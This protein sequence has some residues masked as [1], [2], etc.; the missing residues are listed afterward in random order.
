MA[1]RIGVD[2]NVSTDEDM[3]GVHAQ[4]W[5]TI[6]TPPLP[7]DIEMGE[8]RSWPPEPVSC[9]FRD[10]RLWPPVTHPSAPNGHNWNTIAKYRERIKMG[11]P[12]EYHLQEE[13][14]WQRKEEREVKKE[15]DHYEANLKKGMPGDPN[16]Q[17]EWHRQRWE[18]SHAH[19]T[20]EER[21]KCRQNA[22]DRVEQR[23]RQKEDTKKRRTQRNRE[24]I[25][26]EN[27]ARREAAMRKPGAEHKLVLHRL[28]DWNSKLLRPGIHHVRFEREFE[29]DE[30]VC[31]LAS[32]VMRG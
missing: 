4:P 13:W 16:L 20:P 11:M 12:T 3:E 14:L 2:Q 21:D 23:E 10:P 18:A 5:T 8:S 7:P 27:M 32:V 15:K 6:K 31:R 9:D 17:E 19:L 26:E 29:V 22:Q 24:K 28:S 25:K 1:L 30:Y